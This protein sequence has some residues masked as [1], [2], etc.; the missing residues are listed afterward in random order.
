MEKNLRP[1]EI[2]KKVTTII[3]DPNLES[4]DIVYELHTNNLIFIFRH[5][6]LLKEANKSE[7]RIWLRKNTKYDYTRYTQGKQ[8]NLSNNMLN[9]LNKVKLNI[10]K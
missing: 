2:L 8:Y 1:N 3:I 7:N 5:D 4:K 10:I 9:L 6:D